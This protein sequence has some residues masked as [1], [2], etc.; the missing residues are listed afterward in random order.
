MEKEKNARQTLVR[1][2]LIVIAI[3]AL[4]A[5]AWCVWY[6]VQY[7]QGARHG[8]EVQE[9]GV[10]EIPIIDP[11]DM[12]EVV[13]LPV[14][15]EAL[16][17]MNPDVYAWVTIP[18]TAINYPVV[19]RKGDVGFYANHSSDGAYY[20][21]GSIYS[22]EYNTTTF[23]DPVTVLYGHNLRNGTMF[24]QLNDF[25]D[26]EVFA[27]HPQIYVYTQDKMRI[28]QIFFAGVHSNEHL[29]LNH[30]FTERE[31]YE[32]FFADL[33]DTRSLTAQLR[34][35]DFPQYGEDT[36][37]VL[38]TCFRGNN[39]QRFLVQGRLLAEIPVEYTTTH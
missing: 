30:D 20:T 23:R 16:Q 11:A 39:R 27:Q 21:G 17:A 25:A 1:L 34:E 31:D 15:F 33:K 29:L 18:G 22:E 7:Y 12:P 24:A 35:E 10:T 19:Q 36:V 4:L 5:I 26:A 9:I 3:A 32:T 38:S 37:L 2:I 6:L 8:H 13:D 28:Y 14:D